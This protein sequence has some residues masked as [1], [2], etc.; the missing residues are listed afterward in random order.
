MVATPLVFG[1]VRTF[2]LRTKVAEGVNLVGQTGKSLNAILVRVGDIAKVVTEISA[3]AKEQAMGLAEVNNA[4]N[5]MDQTTQR[6]AAMVEQTTAAAHT[7]R[8][9]AARLNETV[10]QFQ[11]DSGAGGRRVRGP[12][13]A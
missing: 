13:A 5:H 8:Q 6:N 2:A 4:V 3:S 12:A 11:L 1:D 7:L 9:E 10:G